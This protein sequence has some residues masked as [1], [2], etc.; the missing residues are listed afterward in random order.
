MKRN[1]NLSQQLVACILLVSLCLQS[2]SSFTNP[3]LPKPTFSIQEL[4]NQNPFKQLADKQLV[5]KE[6]YQVSFYEKAGRLQAIIK[7]GHGSLSKTHHLPVHIDSD[8]NLAQISTLSES[9]KNR[10]I[11]V[12]L[13]KNNQLGSVVLYKPGLMGGGKSE[14]EQEQEVADEPEQ[15]DLPLQ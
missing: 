11:Q 5:S 14:D 4:G 8:I 7:E 10:L 12:N 15:E 13:P 9:E 2:C 6:G 1:Y 3:P